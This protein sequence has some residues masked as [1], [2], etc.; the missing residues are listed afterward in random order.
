MFHNWE[1]NDIGIFMLRVRLAILFAG[2][3]GLGFVSAWAI[4]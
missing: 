3:F 1:L 2:F 4:K